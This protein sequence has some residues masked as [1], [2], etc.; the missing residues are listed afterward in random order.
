MGDCVVFNVKTIHAATKNDDGDQYR[1]SIDTRVHALTMRTAPVDAESVTDGQTETTT[2]LAASP[3]SCA[4]LP[5]MSSPSSSLAAP[6]ISLSPLS[7]PHYSLLSPAVTVAR[8]SWCAYHT[9]LLYC[10]LRR[11]DPSSPALSRR[12]CRSALLD[13]LTSYGPPAATGLAAQAPHAMRQMQN[14][15][16]AWDGNERQT[17]M[18]RGDNE[19]VRVHE[20]QA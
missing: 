18:P 6:S 5:S 19:Y 20:A 11:H 9:S 2:A 17:M 13:A 12:D 4:S 10:W 14:E 7:T 8:L 1:L 16:K 15:W 3:I